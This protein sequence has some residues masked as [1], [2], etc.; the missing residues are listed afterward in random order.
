[1]NVPRQDF[2]PRSGLS[3]NQDWH[4]RADDMADF[5]LKIP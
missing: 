4:L 1:M 3:L 5:S 2:L